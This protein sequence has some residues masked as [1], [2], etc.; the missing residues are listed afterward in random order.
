MAERIVTVVAPVYRNESTLVELHRR[1]SDAIERAGAQLDLILVSDASPDGS[2]ARIEALAASDPRV[3]AILLAKNVG[4]H[5]AVIEGLRRARGEVV[6]VLDADLQD[7][8]EA[9]PTLLAKLA[10]GWDAVF[11]GR[12]GRYESLG[13]LATSR[14][15]KRL[16]ALAAGIPHDA[17][18]YVAMTRAVADRVAAFPESRPFVV[19]MIG[20]TG[21][22]TTSIPVRRAAAAGR[23]SG[24]TSWKRLRTGLSA[25]FH[26]ALWRRL[27]RSHHG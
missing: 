21:A 23:V 8:P 19:A 13:R 15:F 7:P 9:I 16:L 14:A 3:Q 2:A 6:V 5:R 17:G 26:V 25:L 4:Q 22:R 20:C 11:A 24:Y 18:M 27:L 1:V 12:C 10:S